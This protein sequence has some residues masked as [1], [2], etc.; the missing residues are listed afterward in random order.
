MRCTVLFLLGVL[1]LA[2][3]VEG[4]IINAATGEGIADGSILIRAVGGEGRHRAT[5]D[6][7]G[8]FRID[9]L[10]PG[11]YS[12]YYRARGFFNDPDL[13]DPEHQPRFQI[14][15]G[16][17]IVHL[18]FKLQGLPKLAG[19]VLDAGGRPVAGAR[20]WVLGEQTHCNGLSCYPVLKQAQTGEKG[21]YLFSDVDDPEPS[22]IIAAMAPPSLEAPASTEGRP[23]GYA[24]TFY[25]NATDVQLAGKV[26]A[27]PGTEHWNLDIKLATA[28]VHKI[29]GRL[30]DPAGES[31][32]GVR[33][34]LYNGLGPTFEQT[35]GS[36][37]GFEFASVTGGL[38]RLSAVLERPGARLWTAQSLRL[39]DRDSD[40][41]Q[42][43]LVAAFSEHGKVVFD[44][45]QGTPGPRSMPHVIFTYDPGEFGHDSSEATS[46]PI[47][48]PDGNGNFSVSLYPG[49]Y[50]V[51]VLD[52]PSGPYYLESIRAGA[53]DA[54]SSPAVP[55][56]TDSD[57]VTVTFRY[58]GGTV[59]GAVD[60]CGDARVLLIP[61]DPVL[62]RAGL[63]RETRCGPNGQFEF[64]AVRPGEYYGVAMRG[65]QS[66]RI[67]PQLQRME[68]ITVRNNEH[69][70]AQ[71]PVFQ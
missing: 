22:W 53:N 20:V 55:L 33:V 64:P 26:A 27:R 3:Q 51:Y 10:A 35:T 57:T 5:T 30:A 65:D 49:M 56:L 39:G 17:A 28:P 40:P 12:T 62:R 19:R 47:G 18:E 63:V 37:G 44:V 8:H 69:T 36:D 41:V 16:G 6:A 38:W 60:S 68:K 7:Q 45:P 2:A 13:Q 32:A 66:R 31:V 61:I 14:T 23:L 54:L 34:K 59:G 48:D 43:R 21:D 25:P 11:T 15:A 50:R 58:G 70:A 71:I 1:P 29:R 24:Q 67:E 46:V 52:S 42:L 9:D 4:R